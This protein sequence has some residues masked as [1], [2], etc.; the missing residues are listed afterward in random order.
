MSQ[1]QPSL[2]YSSTSTS[3]SN[4]TL[5]EQAHHEKA[6][7]LRA[8]RDPQLDVN[9]PYRT[10]SDDA[11]LAEYTTTNPSGEIPGPVNPETHM[12][13]ELVTFTPDDKGNPKNW[14]KPFKW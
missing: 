10:L 7:S 6:H 5:A 4:R 9:L 3:D 12:P 11:N 1:V 8:H 2:D 13:Y 14:S